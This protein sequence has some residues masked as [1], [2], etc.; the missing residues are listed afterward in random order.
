MPSLGQYFQSRTIAMLPYSSRTLLIMLF[1]GVIGVFGLSLA[2]SGSTGQKRERTIKRPPW[3]SEPIKIEKI[4][5]R[6]MP[7]SD[8]KFLEDDDW[9]KSLTLSVKNTSGRIIKYI[10]IDLIF[11]RPQDSPGER[12]SRDHLMYGQYPLLPGE[13]VSPS[14]EP[15]VMPNDSVNITLSDYEGTM[16]FLKQTSYGTSIKDLELEISMVIFDDDTKWSGGQLYRRDPNNPDGWIPIPKRQDK[17]PNGNNAV[18]PR[19]NVDFALSFFDVRQG[20]LP[21]FAK[22]AFKSPP[23]LTQDD[24][25]PCT[26]MFH[27]GEVWYAQDLACTS[28][29]CF[30]RRDYVACG[31]GDAR[32][33]YLTSQNDRCVN[34]TTR[35]AC[36]VYRFTWFKKPCVWI[37]ETPQQCSDMGA[38]WNYTTNTCEEIPEGCGEPEDCSAYGDPP[39]IWE[40]YPTCACVDRPSPVLIDVAGDGFAMTSAGDGVNFDLNANGGLERLSW[41]AAASDDAWLILDRNG[42]GTIDN[43]T[44]LFGNYTAQPE[45]P[46]GTGRNGF[47]ALAEYDKPTN[48]GNGDGLINKQDAI[49]QSLRLWQDTNHNGTSE[50]FELHTLKDLGLKVI[51]LDYKT[52]KRTDQYGN[53]FRYRAKV[54]DTHDAQL[55]RWAWDV[56]LTTN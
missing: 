9:L 29:G 4:K 25:G 30:V 2:Q 24:P 54:K 49:F 48:G 26:D 46:A 39:M 15:P 18:R 14:S 22:L 43:G 21:M 40:D 7:V 34:R 27:C 41:T 1:M 28:A 23:K 50:A 10:E 56:F 13:A 5:L 38:S 53:L 33:H 35:R 32:Q 8:Q 16:E 51:D 11:P 36:S 42:N 6:G 45:P 52:S 44:E 20:T 12:V 47:L 31:V 37:A 3:R 17:I 55:G 19:R